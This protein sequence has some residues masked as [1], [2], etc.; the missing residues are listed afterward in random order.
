MKTQSNKPFAT[1][2]RFGALIGWSPL[3]IC[4]HAI[5][6]EQAESGPHVVTWYES[7]DSGNPRTDCFLQI[8]ESPI[9]QSTTY[10]GAVYAI[11]Y[12]LCTGWHAFTLH[13]N[14]RDIK[15]EASRLSE[16]LHRD[17]FDSIAKRR[18]FRMLHPECVG[19]SWKKIR[20]VGPPHEGSP[21]TA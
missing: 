20:D 12:R 18:E 4:Q 11:R 3:R 19:Y 10:N 1:L 14:R 16:W 21:E 6:G 7:G 15:V 9:G 8:N 5:E 13:R 17:W 2:Q